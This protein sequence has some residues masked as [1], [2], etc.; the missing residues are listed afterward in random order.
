MTLDFGGVLSRAWKIVW[1]NKILWLFGILSALMGGQAS[2]STSNFRFDSSNPERSLP[3]QLRDLDPNIIL[4]IIAGVVL[5]I[6]VIAIVLFI[7]SIFGRGGLIGGV[8]LADQQGR[9]SFGEAWAVGRRKFWSVLVIGLAVSVLGLLL[10]GVSFVTALTICLLPLACIGFLLLPVLGVYARLA[11]IVAVVDDVGIS[12]A[13]SRG[14]RFISTN[15]ASVIIMGLILVILQAVIGFVLALPFLAIAAPIMLSIAG[16]ATDAPL[17][18]GA[19]LAIAGLC[20]VIYLPVLI[21][22][23]G[24][25]ESWVMAAWTLTYQQLTGRAP[26]SAMPAPLPAA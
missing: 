20:V 21:V 11:Q 9:V 5:V 25:V 10:A 17:A 15:L 3:V 12:E 2:G 23:G 16:Y 4:V 7:L 18:G 1:N 24:I 8:R 22:A 14:W 6:I 13:L 26:A 19:G